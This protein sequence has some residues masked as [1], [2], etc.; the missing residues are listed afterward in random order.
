M[1]PLKLPKVDQ[2]SLLFTCLLKDYDMGFELL[3]HVFLHH[4]SAWQLAATCQEAWDA[5]CEKVDIWDL[6]NGHFN[7]CDKE[8][9]K[10]NTN[11]L[12]AGSVSA[13]LVI[14]PMRRP[15]G[16]AS[17]VEQVRNLRLLK[18]SVLNFGH[19]LRNIYFHR[20]PFISINNLSLLIPQMAKLEIL[21][22]YNCRLMHLAT[23]LKLLELLKVDRLKGK[24]NSVALDW[25]P[26]YHLGPETGAVGT[27]GVCWDN[28]NLD[29]CVGI[30]SIVK[31]LVTNAREQGIDLESPHT[32]FRKWLEKTPCWKVGATLNSFFY[33]G[34]SHLEIA[35]MV[36]YRFSHGNP[37]WFASSMKYKWDLAELSRDFWCRTCKSVQMGIFFPG[38]RGVELS[39]DRQQQ[40]SLPACYGCRLTFLLRRDTDHYK[41]EK[42]RIIKTWLMIDDKT[43]NTDNLRKSIEDYELLGIEELA[44]NLDEK[45]KKHMTLSPKNPDPY[46]RETQE[47]QVPYT[48]HE[49]SGKQGGR[50]RS[51]D[52]NEWKNE[53][54]AYINNPK[55]WS[56]CFSRFH[57]KYEGHGT[58]W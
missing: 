23:G 19:S 9:S 41:V 36:Q 8:V 3:K 20:V 49:C 27:Y 57:E 42:R 44:A 29:T 5:V 11:P 32:M 52:V 31:R 1:G 2:K 22:I 39:S 51:P 10:E 38:W 34:A 21:G 56:M 16:P 13:H 18:L 48:D 58:F 17:Y 33:P 30:W 50:W 47:R 53:E 12:Q 14:T 55:E 35:A 24:E 6:T 54:F 25:Y 37:K 28:L 4:S 45:R 43:W 15:E 7:N 26:N 46:D 40:R